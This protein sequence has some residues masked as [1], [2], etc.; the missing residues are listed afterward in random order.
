V[1][2]LVPLVVLPLGL[3]AWILAFRDQPAEQVD[4]TP[5]QAEVS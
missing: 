2:W 3:G 1:G 4:P 5:E